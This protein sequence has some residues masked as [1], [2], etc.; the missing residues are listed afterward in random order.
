MI[1]LLPVSGLPWL[2]PQNLSARSPHPDCAH[3]TATPVTQWETVGLDFSTHDAPDH[4]HVVA[5]VQNLRTYAKLRNQ[6]CDHVADLRGC[7]I[8][9]MFAKGFA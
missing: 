3:V 9:I 1:I 2:T 5:D 7:Q 4:D 6:V 8:L